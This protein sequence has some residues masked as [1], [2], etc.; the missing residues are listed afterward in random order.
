[1]SNQGNYFLEE[2]IKKVKQ[3]CEELQETLRISKISRY[4]N[5]LVLIAYVICG[6]IRSVFDFKNTEVQTNKALFHGLRNNLCC[7]HRGFLTAVYTY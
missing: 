4:G 6:C 5:M 3:C 1:M 2:Q 7:C